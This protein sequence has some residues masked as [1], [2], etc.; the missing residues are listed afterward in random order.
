M[1]SPQYEALIAGMTGDL[2]APQDPWKVAREKLDA[3]HGHPVPAGSRVTRLELGGVRCAWVEAK[4]AEGRPGAL[5]L[6]H[7]GAFVA[8]VGTGGMSSQRETPP[9]STPRRSQNLW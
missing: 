5:V 1:P 7:G 3:V 2:V 6:C 9:G 8:A 4:E